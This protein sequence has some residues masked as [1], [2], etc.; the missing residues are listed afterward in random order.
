MD[1]SYGIAGVLVGG[2][3]NGSFVAPMKRMSGWKWVED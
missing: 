2:I 3:L 1:L